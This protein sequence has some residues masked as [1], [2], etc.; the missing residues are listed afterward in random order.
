MKK[1]SARARAR[2]SSAARH[3]F[4]HVVPTVIHHPEEKMTVL[5]R[6][7]HHLLQNPRSALGWVGAI[8]AGVFLLVVVWKLGTGGHS[9]TSEVW[10][11]LE[12]AKSPS[13]RVDLAKEHPDSPAA[14]WALLQAAT[15]YYGQAAADLPN[16]RDVALPT[17]KKA[18]ELFEQVERE[19]ARDSVPA[20]A[21][22]IGKARTLEIR[23]D[24]S[25]AIEQYEVVAKNWPGT[26]EA[27]QAQQFAQALKDPGAAAFYK[28]LYT[29]SPTKVTLPPFGS[30]NL[31][32]F[33]G[34]DVTPGKTAGPTTAL[35]PVE[36]SSALPEVFPRTIREVPAARKPEPATA[37]PVETP[38][39]LPDDVFAPK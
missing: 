11:K 34:T 5:G 15:E 27:N 8:A 7:T 2:S 20:R 31:P 9:T 28:E 14:I 30:E 36:R 18:L 37:R 39:D 35:P 38:K 33:P 29:Y 13:D 26:P 24:L 3:Q 16:N 32:L 10:S 21:A 23:G 25:K 19:A 22:A 1:P 4:D 17:S 12:M 6:W